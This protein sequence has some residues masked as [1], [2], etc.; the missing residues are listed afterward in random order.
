MLDEMRTERDAF[1]ASRRNASPCPSH[2]SPP[3]GGGGGYVETRSQRRHHVI[4][5][6]CDVNLTCS[7][8][9]ESDS[10][11]PV[12][13]PVDFPPPPVTAVNSASSSVRSSNVLWPSLEAL[14][15]LLLFIIFSIKRHHP[16]LNQCLAG[17]AA[18]D[19]LIGV[20]S[21]IT[22]VKLRDKTPPVTASSSSSRSSLSRLRLVAPVS[23]AVVITHMLHLPEEMRNV[24]AQAASAAVTAITILL[25]SAALLC[26][27]CRLLW[28]RGN[29]EVAPYPCGGFPKPG[30]DPLPTAAFNTRV[31]NQPC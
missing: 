6:R 19:V 23:C 25:I 11:T 22:L 26:T 10:D 16:P 30:S 13:F 27:G 17:A 9:S 3:G 7:K 29:Q 14:S 28:R 20:F 5:V 4:V 15:L 12:D 18:E 24:Y 21:N 31:L 8:D 1:G 2:R